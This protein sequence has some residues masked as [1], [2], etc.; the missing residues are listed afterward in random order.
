MNDENCDGTVD[1]DTAADA[2]TW[3][4]D[5]DSDGYGDETDSGTTTCTAPPST[6]DNADD[7]DDGETAVNPAATE[8]CDSIDNDCDGLVD[9]DDSDVDLSTGTTWYADADEDGFGDDD[10]T[11]T[12]TCDVPS[13]AQTSQG[14]CDDSE[15]TI[16]P[17]GTEVCDGVNDENCDGTVDEDTASDAST[18]YLDDDGDGYGTSDTS[19][20]SC[21]A[22]TDYV[23]PDGDC[24]DT[25]THLNPDAEE[26]CNGVDDDCDGSIDESGCSDGEA[27]WTDLDTLG[28]E[29]VWAASIY[30]SDEDQILLY[31]GAGYHSLV[32]DVQAYD[33]L[34][35]TWSALSPSGT[36]PGGLRGHGAIYDSPQA[37]MLVF[38]GETY[39]TLSSDLYAL[40]TTPGAEDWDVVSTSGSTP[41]PRTGASVVLDMDRE[42][43]LV[44]GGSG[45]H[46][47]LNDVWELDLATDAWTEL[48][49]G[50]SGVSDTSLAFAA[51]VYDPLY[52]AVYV[53]G[54][55]TYHMLADT[56]LC[57]DLSASTET[58]KELT[59][60]GA[61]LPEVTDATATWAEGYRAA[62]LHG[63]STYHA[64]SGSTWLLE[65]T[66]AC[67]VTVTELT[68]SGDSPGGLTGASLS[69]AESSGVG[70][71]TGGQTYYK[72]NG[73]T[74]ELAP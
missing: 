58:W 42:R 2:A 35:N 53:L 4:D 25:D 70:V 50:L 61:S 56:A 11:G 18:W 19:V 63:G 54:G 62:V 8:Q 38:G 52:E 20:V 33:V 31:G 34:T 45:Y 65:P 36:S 59:T 16:N 27:N 3:Y 24:D 14:D 60:T 32:D 12:T 44:I 1:E 5:D 17:D 55:E 71:L 66:A 72:L 22:P 57:L 47:L 46:G 29:V 73:S 26:T 48:S 9:D 15:T 64:L 10:D 13:G 74:V 67:E 49:P 41:D 68:E 30:D 69:W 28:T 23:E 43:M 37:R 7:C 39:H 21:E 40:D 51:A 6:V